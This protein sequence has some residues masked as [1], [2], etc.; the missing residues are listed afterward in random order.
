M[1][2]VISRE[3]VVVSR[4]GRSQHMLNNVPARMY[5]KLKPLMPQKPQTPKVMR[6][7]R[8]RLPTSIWRARPREC[9]SR[10]FFDVDRFLKKV[11]VADLLQTRLERLLNGDHD[12]FKQVSHV[13]SEHFRAVRLT[14]RYW[15]AVGTG[16]PFSLQWNQ[17]RA[18]CKATGCLCDEV[19]AEE[20]DV[21]FMAANV[22][23]GKDPSDAKANPDKSATRY[24]F[25]ECLYRIAQKKYTSRTAETPLSPSAALRLLLERDVLP[26]AERAAVHRAR[27]AGGADLR[28]RGGHE[29]RQRE[30][31][32]GVWAQAHLGVGEQAWRRDVSP[33]WLK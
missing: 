30:L 27:A 32:D 23:V 14:F 4:D 19:S 9:D 16:E 33:N 29:S 11:A 20:L 15:A 22:E 10:T 2:N 3:C 21:I 18:F 25:I 8:W 5:E 31:R 24:E 1:R 7:R 26:K 12:E 17:W 13:V 28:A 6:R